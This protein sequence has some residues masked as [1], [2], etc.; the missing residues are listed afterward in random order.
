MKF[1]GKYKNAI[2]TIL[3]E[4]Y[5]DKK[6]FKEN[7][8]IVMGAMK[9]SKDFREFFTL[10]NEMEQKTISEQNDA[11]EYINES[12]D[13]LRSK[14]SNLKKT[15]PIFDNIITRKL[16]N[17]KLKS[18]PI[19]ESL[20][21]LI[22]KTGAK[23]IEKRVSSKK[24]LLESLQREQ[25]GVKLNRGYSTKIL[26]KTL[27]KN[28]NEEFKNLTESEKVLF[29]NIISL[30]EKN[31]NLEFNK[32]KNKL[33]ENINTLISET[34]EDQL[35]TRLVETKNSILT[36]NV[37]RKNLLSIKQLSQDLK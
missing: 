4:S 1:F 12:I 36:M 24:T 30:D 10:Y 7:F 5:S 17:K 37:N 20:D 19:Y 27:S 3:A 2:D 15:L 11:R 34:K 8:H 32:T 6:L 21:Y 23:S 25:K 22:F 18:N 9:F 33:V 26:S 31:I 29:N 14:V 13:L 35:V 28:F 16:K